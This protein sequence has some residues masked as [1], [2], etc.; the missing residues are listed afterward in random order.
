MEPEKTTTDSITPEM[1]QQLCKNKF[2]FFVEHILGLENQPFHDEIDDDISQTFS[3][4]DPV[5]RFF[6]VITMPRDHGKSKHLSIAYP[7]WRIA[8]NH[9]IRILAIS[10]TSKIAESFLSEIISNIERNDLYRDWAEQIDP[11]R[12][13]V[14][15]R[16]KA[17]RK[18]QQDWSGNSITI[19][20][21]TIDMKDP[22]I[23]ATGL[24]GQI[25][26]RRADIIICDDIVDQENSFTEAQRIKVR[27][28]ID[29]TV[30]PVLV[31]GGT[32][33]YLGNT[34][35]MDD[36]VSKFMTDPRF[37]VQKRQGAIIKEADRQDLW[38]EWGALMVNITID[39]KTRRANANTFYEKNKEEMDRG[40]ETLWPDR[41]PYAR[42]YFERMLNPYMFAR[43]YQCDPS[44]RPDQVI[45]DE[46]IMA[47]LE[48]GKSLRFQDLPQRR[49]EG[50][51]PPANFLEVSAGG[52]DLAI[53][54]EEHADDTALV[55]VDLVRHGYDDVA[56]GDYLLRQIYRDHF[57]P[58]EQ[59]TLPVTAW[60]EHGLNSIRVESVGYQKS[61]TI[62]LSEAGVPITAYNTGSEKFDPEIGINMVANIMEQ[63]RMV[64]PSD[65]TDPRTVDLASKL[66]NEMRAFPDGHTGDS[67]MALWFAISE[68][69]ELM[70]TRL[71]VPGM[72]DTIQDSPS[73]VTAEERAPM[74]KVADQAAIDEQNYERS[75]FNSMMAATIRNRTR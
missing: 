2:R 16:L 7:L 59:R 15:P 6:S 33:I 61:L 35:H 32:F 37:M 3:S 10:R 62:D 18:M 22:T 26:S 55:Y 9:N 8:K 53:S 5:A 72:V 31:P 27:D 40:W 39:P 52:M 67:L 44:N 38:K 41:Y 14:I 58:N 69:R 60:K 47:A 23:A 24:F 64:I 28:W 20:R 21:E 73:V 68:I 46:W 74:E 1:V 63:G 57:T 13:G 25:L 17:G 43:M 34:W 75:A 49:A 36:V 56:D 42:L 19:E 54:Q 65:P 4:D 12:R 29:T 66:A 50:S 11:S 70:G 30:I 51:S 45:K 48:K 71:L